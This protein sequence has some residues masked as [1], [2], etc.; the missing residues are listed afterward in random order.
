MITRSLGNKLFFEFCSA[1]KRPQTTVDSPQM[2]KRYFK[3][4]F[5]SLLEG[6]R[7]FWSSKSRKESV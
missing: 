6:K 4:I 3:L 5:F 2:M 1:D 7:I